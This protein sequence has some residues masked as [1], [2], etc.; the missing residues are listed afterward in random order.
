MPL[1][2]RA[3][4]GILDDHRLDDFRFALRFLPLSLPFFFP[5]LHS[6]INEDK[7]ETN[8]VARNR[9]RNRLQRTY[10]VPTQYSPAQ[11]YI[12]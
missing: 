4:R 12:T 9:E 11:V 6:S 10:S 8:L 1:V 5:T 2:S 3:G 7:E